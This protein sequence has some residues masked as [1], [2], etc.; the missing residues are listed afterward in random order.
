MSAE[1]ATLK[2]ISQ[3][4]V[5]RRLSTASRAVVAHVL[6]E[7]SAN[8]GRAELSLR[9]ICDA[10]GL[11]R[12]TA[13]AAIRRGE[14]LEYFGIARRNGCRSLFLPTVIEAAAA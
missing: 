3:L 9:E 6:C 7:L 8:G 10:V 11:D 2:R 12:R 14:E 13:R 1:A 4:T 5:D